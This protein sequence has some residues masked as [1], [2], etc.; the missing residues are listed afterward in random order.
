MKLRKLTSK[1]EFLKLNNLVND[2]E[3][4]KAI[5]ENKLSAWADDKKEV[6]EAEALEDLRIMTERNNK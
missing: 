1:D 2:K 5:H 4:E 3:V 6:E